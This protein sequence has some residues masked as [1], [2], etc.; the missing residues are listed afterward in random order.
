MKKKILEDLSHSELRVPFREF[1]LLQKM[2]MA[3]FGKKF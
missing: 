2:G 1:E 3:Q